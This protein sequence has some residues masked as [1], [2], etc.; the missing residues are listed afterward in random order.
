METSFYA[1]TDAFKKDFYLL[2]FQNETILLK[3]SRIFEFEQILALLE[4]KVHQT[5]LEIN[6]GSVLHNLQQY[7]QA[8]KPSTKIMAMVKASSYGSGS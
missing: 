1:S 4:Q 6:L 8:L 5:V 2:K 7:Q 3:G